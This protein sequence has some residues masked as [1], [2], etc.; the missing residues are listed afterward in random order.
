MISLIFFV[1]FVNSYQYSWT[2]D[3][4]NSLSHVPDFI[5]DYKN[6]DIKV[7]TNVYVV[8]SG[9]IESDNFYNNIYQKIN[10]YN[11][12]DEDQM[13]H[14]TFVASQIS[15][16]KYG[17]TKNV[18]MTIIKVFGG[19][20]DLSLS[21]HLEDA[22]Q[23]IEKD[24]KT[25][26]NNCVINLS[27]GLSERHEPTDNLLEK[28]HNQNILIVASAGNDGKN[29]KD[30]TPSHLP[31]LLV[32]GSNNYLDIISSYSNYGECVDIY[33]Y[34]ELVAGI[35]SK[36]KLS[37]RSGTSMSAPIITGYISDYWNKYPTLTNNE[38]QEKFLKE[39]STNKYKYKLFTI[40]NSYF[41]DMIVIFFYQ[42]IFGILYSLILFLKLF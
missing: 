14:G 16:K 42:I 24:C 22:L 26:T 39:Y 13:G 10:F 41:N 38:I 25:T 29:C 32:V 4:I 40:K 17:V 35:S 9:I 3:K 21:S 7:N 11:D 34:G 5:I 2:L 23:F 27:L 15:S 12:I 20:T 30:F 8:D 31:F 19:K 1:S 28:L 36:N 18:N 6:E 37:I 33:T